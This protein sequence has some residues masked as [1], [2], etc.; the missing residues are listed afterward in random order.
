MGSYYKH[1][2]SEHIELPYSFQCEHCGKDSGSMRAVITGADAI[3]NNYTKTLNDKQEEKLHQEAHKNLVKEIKNVHKDVVEKQ[4]YPTEFH[5]NCPSCHQ[6][7]SWAVSGLQKKKYQ[8][9]IVCLA[10][11]IFFGLWALLIYFID[12]DPSM[13]ATM[14]YTAAVIFVVGVVSAIGCLLWNIR[15]INQ[16]TKQTSSGVQHVPVI[17][18]GAVQHLLNEQ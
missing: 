3:Y 7:Q 17:E 14:P 12:D 2:R 8:N 5:D 16:K 10:L 18:W 13:K 11:G 15:K 1:T 4:I 6:P 9:P